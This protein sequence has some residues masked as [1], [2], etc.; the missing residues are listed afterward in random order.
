MIWPK[1][2]AA[3]RG[4]D[5]ETACSVAAMLAH[6]RAKTKVGFEEFERAFGRLGHNLPSPVESSADV[7]SFLKA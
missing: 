2:V 4:R 6:G 3:C 7:H 5:I 1:P